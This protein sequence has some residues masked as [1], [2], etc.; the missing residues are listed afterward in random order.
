MSTVITA[1]VYDTQLGN[2]T[3]KWVLFLIADQ[4]NVQGFGWPSIDFIMKITEINQR[5]VRRM[6]QIFEEIGLLTKTNRGPRATP[7]LQ[8]N[9]DRLGLDLRAEFAYHFQAAQGKTPCF[10]HGLRDHPEAVSET[11]QTV[12][13]TAQTVSET[14]PPH[15]LKGRPVKDPLK[16]HPYSPQRGHAAPIPN[17]SVDRALDA[18]M[19]ACGFTSA[20]LRP[21]LR[22]VVEQEADKGN[23]PPCCALEMTH[24]WQ[25]F[26][27]QGSVLR[28]KWTARRFYE[29][30]YWRK[31]E[32]WPWDE[33]RIEERRSKH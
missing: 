20:R 13:E 4:A 19:Q 10:P 9:L 23:E 17:P 30:G 27:G 11:A 7:G 3:A 33:A 26:T 24:A 8:L 18:I 1:K 31:P 22:K 29:E 16:T 32:S 2:L 6:I 15:P 25:L 5:T 12:L 14:A 21:V 28:F